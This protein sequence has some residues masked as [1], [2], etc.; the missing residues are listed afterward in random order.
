MEHSMTLKENGLYASTTY[1]YLRFKQKDISEYA[2]GNVNDDSDSQS[3]SANNRVIC[4]VC[5][6]VHM[7]KGIHVSGVNKIQNMS[8]HLL[9]II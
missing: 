3:E 6:S 2:N 4:D 8:S 9:L 7:K 5:I 1:F